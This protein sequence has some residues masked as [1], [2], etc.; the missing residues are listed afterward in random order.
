M[1]SAK[2]TIGTKVKWGSNYIGEVKTIGDIG[3]S[4]N[5]EIDVTHLT[6]PAKEVI[7]G[8]ADFGEI[9]ISGNWIPADLGQSDLMADELTGTTDTLCFEF[10][11]AAKKA[12]CT[13]FVKS[14]KVGSIQVEGAYQ[15]TATFRVSG[16]ITFAAIGA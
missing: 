2:S 10:T 9:T 11:N 7:S 3:N 14:F 5:A 8:L 12:T 6:S 1:S 16:S 15:F 13:A 4:G